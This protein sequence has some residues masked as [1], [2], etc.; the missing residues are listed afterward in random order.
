ME[1]VTL[2]SPPQE[3]AAL[4]FDKVLPTVI[5][6]ISGQ[7]AFGWR[8]K[9]SPQ[10]LEAVKRLFASEESV[11]LSGKSFPVEEAAGNF[12]RQIKSRASEAGLSLDQ[13]VVT[14]PAN[15]RGMARY[16]TK[17]SAGLAGIEVLALVNE[18]TAAA[19]AYGTR[20]KD[21]DRVL[22]FDW[23]GGTLD[24]TILRRVAGVFM[25]EASKG[26]QKLGGIDLDQ[27]F[28]AAV[29][30]RVPSDSHLDLFDLE[31]AKVILSSQE[32]TIIPLVGGGTLEVTRSDLE[33]SIRPLILRTQ[34]PVRR[35]LAD[36]SDPKIDHLVLVGGS[37][38]IPMVQRYIRE[39]LRLDVI[40]GVDPM[41]AVAE[42]AALAAGILTGEIS[43][44]DF[45]V[46]TE[47]A[48]G[49]V[50]HDGGVP[51]FSVLIPRNTK[52]PA[53]ATDF[54]EP[55][56]DD[57]ESAIVRVMEGD[58]EQA[59]EH[60]DNVILK[61]WEVQL[62][63]RSR[64]QAGFSIT[65]EYD[66]DG[67]LHVKVV[68]NMTQLKLMDE[69]LTFGA[70]RSKQDLVDIRRRIDQ[71]SVLTDDVADQGA[72]E[73]TRS[74][75]SEQS[76]EAVRRAKEKIYPFVDDSIQKLLDHQIESLLRSGPDGEVA[77]R[78]QLEQTIRDHAYL[79]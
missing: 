6:D 46:G 53:S 15:S 9:R 54:Y 14:I 59:F 12:F 7:L 63:K 66:V 3:W 37:S 68:D 47:H 55:V 72:K 42:G 73:S 27:A 61:E 35:C 25:E 38:K 41:T 74:G 19:M 76:R 20:I 31:R 43:D 49:T 16:R 39:M 17:I 29:Q 51:R 52:L 5:A 13:A 50:V 4:G 77:A 21:G 33:A 28:A 10:R 58:P 69:Q 71:S 40:S 67:I 11:E 48:L 24:V 57:Q 64:A 34:E 45:F 78:D 75:L 65:F 56:H 32:S 44:Y 18:P 79:L 23:G 62:E 30:N 1:T 70:A 36:L 60:E 26:V 2:D 8:A 22:V